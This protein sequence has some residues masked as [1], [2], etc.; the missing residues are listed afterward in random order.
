MLKPA[1]P[2][3]A[4]AAAVPEGFS[5]A[6]MLNVLE[7]ISQKMDSMDSRINQQAMVRVQTVAAG[8]TS[9]T[10]AGQEADSGRPARRARLGDDRSD[11]A[12]PDNVAAALLRRGND[13]TP[14]SSDGGGPH[15]VQDQ[16][17]PTR[18]RPGGFFGLEKDTNHL[19]VCIQ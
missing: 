4:P 18:A 15:M 8:S 13:P 1:A 7:G 5:M 9:P 14:K 17:D 10:C 2:A 16:D 19:Y 6:A 3:A 12:H 11:P